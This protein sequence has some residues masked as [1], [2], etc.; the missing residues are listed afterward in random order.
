MKIIFMGTPE[1]AVPIFKSIYSS[2][3]KISS[4]YTQPPKEKFRGKK[5]IETQIHMAAK[6]LNVEVRSPDDLKD[7]LEEHNFIKT[8]SP[9]IVVVA[10][11]GRLLP[12]SILNIPNI[13]FINVHA[14]LLPKLRGAAPIQRAIMEMHNETGIS[15]MKIVPRLDAGPFMLQDKIKIDKN[16]NF[17]T[18]SSKLS[19]L[20]SKMILEALD[21]LD[22][23][24][25]VFKEQ[26]EN[27]ATYAKK[28][29]KSE[30]AINWNS[31]ANEL[32]SKINA[33]NPSPGAWF[34]H[35]GTRL[36]IVQAEVSS[37]EG[38]VGK[39]LDNELT[40]GCSKDS[41]KVKLIQK[42]CKKILNTKDFLSGYKIKKSEVLN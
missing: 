13:T 10:A 32:V 33:L 1:F 23:G 38:D 36:K 26:N 9:A 41:L 31:S 17:S 11:Y 14:S 39:I 24:K 30:S 7:N 42:A 25:A 37:L 19:N 20:G 16:D 18:L 6:K 29:E 3:H 2:R 5:V 15:I 22:S 28:I 12:K 34:I 35:K 21:L 40:I 4:V 27:E 8:S